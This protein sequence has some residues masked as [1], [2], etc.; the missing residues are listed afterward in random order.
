MESK[1]PTRKGLITYPVY[2]VLL[3]AHQ[4]FLLTFLSVQVPTERIR[5]V[6]AWN[7]ILEGLKEEFEQYYLF[8][9]ACVFF[10][11]RLYW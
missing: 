3:I 1:M 8:I 4:C 6:D 5:S 9:R 11:E 7:I 10:L 2:Y